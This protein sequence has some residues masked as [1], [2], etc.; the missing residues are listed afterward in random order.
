M[1]LLEYYDNETKTLTLPYNFNQKLKNIPKETQKIIFTEN[2]N[3]QEYSNFDQLINDLPENLTCLILGYNFNKQIDKLPVNLKYLTL[4]GIFNRTINNLPLNLTHLTFKCHFHK[5]IE[6]LPINIE[7]LILEI[8]YYYTDTKLQKSLPK[9]MPKFSKMKELKLNIGF[10]NEK[11]DFLPQNLI[12]LFIG[13]NIKSTR[14]FFPI[15][16]THLTFDNYYDTDNLIDFCLPPN[17]TYLKFGLFSRSKKPLVNLPSKLTHLC[18]SYHFNHK[19]DDLPQSLTHLKL[20]YLFN[21]SLD[22]LPNSLKFLSLYEQ[23]NI[24]LTKN[25][26]ELSL[27]HNNNLINNLPENIEKIYIKFNDNKMSVVNNLPLTIKEIII[28]S[29]KYKKY[30]KIP[31]G[32]ILTIQKID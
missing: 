7:N 27:M 11:I 15:N 3:K 4:R 32:A 2:C 19:I 30:I 14:I 9:F 10:Y 23:K 6:N 5:S 25:I 17:L 20:G 12:K 29:E 18:L 24:K 28:T 13:D 1:S 8:P 26:K 31:F 21:Q 22:N 16:L